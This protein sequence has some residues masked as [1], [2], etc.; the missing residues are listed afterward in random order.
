MSE[1][2]TEAPAEEPGDER[3][4]AILDDM[5]RELGPASEAAEEWARRVLGL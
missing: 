2:F 4:I 1:E 3:L 5:D